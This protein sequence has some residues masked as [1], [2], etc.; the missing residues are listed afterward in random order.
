ML[1]APASAAA[2]GLSL[3]GLR[4]A[5]HSPGG[6]LLE[7]DAA[8]L[9][10][11]LLATRSGWRVGREGEAPTLS[12]I[13]GE[14]LGAGLACD[15]ACVGGPRLATT[16]AS[17]A[18]LGRADPM[19]MLPRDDVLEGISGSGSK[20]RRMFGRGRATSHLRANCRAGGRMATWRPRGLVAAS[21]LSETAAMDRQW[22][23]TW[24]AVHPRH[25]AR[26]VRIRSGSEICTPIALHFRPLAAD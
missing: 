26:L 9:S 16:L 15:A 18:G 7:L 25:G 12:G 10:A 3:L 23:L 5:R 1:P 2:K 20:G 22:S 4:P 21:G 11:S 8:R 14:R 13:L 17:L 6:A 19:L 24:S